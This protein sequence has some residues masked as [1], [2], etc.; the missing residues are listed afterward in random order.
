M[1]QKN[2]SCQQND[3]VER[4]KRNARNQKHCKRH[5]EYLGCVQHKTQQKQEKKMSIW[6]RETSRTVRHEKKNE[7][8]RGYNCVEISH[9]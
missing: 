9:I 7:K 3:M 8:S 4:K 2:G 1:Q 5:Q 6:L